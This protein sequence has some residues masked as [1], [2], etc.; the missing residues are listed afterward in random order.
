MT[1]VFPQEKRC[2]HAGAFGCAANACVACA[3]LAIKKC[4]ILNSTKA[5]CAFVPGCPPGGCAP[6]GNIASRFSSRVLEGAR[7][8][9]VPV[10]AQAVRVMETSHHSQAAARP[11]AARLQTSEERR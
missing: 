5:E 4:S 2:A 10:T 1:P 11:T 3:R 6:R 7:R 9:R 8:A